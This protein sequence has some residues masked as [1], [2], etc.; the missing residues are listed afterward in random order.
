MP[1]PKAKKPAPKKK[2][3]KKAASSP[4]LVP[5]KKKRVYTPAQRRRK[6]NATRLLQLLKQ[7]KEREEP[8]APAPENPSGSPIKLRN[9]FK[10]SLREGWTQHIFGTGWPDETPFD[11]EYLRKVELRIVFW[12][13]GGIP[14]DARYRPLPGKRDIEEAL[15]RKG[16]R[17]S[18]YEEDTKVTGAVR[19]T[20]HEDWVFQ[21]P[22]WD[23]VLLSGGSLVPKTVTRLLNQELALKAVKVFNRLQL[24]DVP[25]TPTLEDSAGDWFREVVGVIFGSYDPV[26]RQRMIKELFLLV[27]KKNMKTT[28]GALIMLLLLIFN[29]RPNGQAIMT[30]PVHDVAE[31]AFDAISGAIRLDPD[32]A[33]VFEVKEHFKTVIDRRTNAVLRVLTFDPAVLTGQKVFAALIDE[34]HVISKN[35]KA[36][37]A[38]RQIRGGML[39]FPEAIMIFITTQSEEAPAGVFLS[40]LTQA[41]AIRDGVR[42][43]SR[44]LPILYE[45]PEKMQ[46]DVNQPWRKPKTWKLV[47]PNLG[48]SISLDALTASYEDAEAKGESEMR[49]WASQHL[50]IEIG[51]ALRSN[52]WAGAALWST[53]EV[54]LTLTL[55]SLLERCEVVDVGVDGG[56]MDD[57][58]GLAVV[59]REKVTLKWLVWGKAW[60]HPIVFDRNKQIAAQLEDFKKSG[61]LSVV[62]FPGADIEEL[63]DLILMVHKTGLLDKIGLDPYGVGSIVDALLTAGVPEDMIAGVSQGWRMGGAVKTVERAVAEKKLIHANQGILNWCIS[64]AQVEARGN[65]VLITKAA[66]GSA[67]IDVLMAVLDA[68][69]LLSANPA[70]KSR[71]FQMFIMG[72]KG[73]SSMG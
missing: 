46:K 61:D 1:K 5:A 59:G 37:S 16:F 15:G 69:S 43:G 10:G 60:A 8:F 23:K 52:S 73:K 42:L 6:T 36:A 38:I 7:K 34:L 2:A 64:N 22:E 13:T 4:P 39:P 45:F 70:A 14:H 68:V 58:L 18:R 40:E 33:R 65:A 19:S 41:R 47:T 56:G 51:M 54:D 50:N 3:P 44:I 72:G 9:R 71:K 26:T 48:M 28:G 55:K 24:A 63:V 12:D 66:S 29:E 57:L 11:D 35:P 17:G 49:S 62:D 21:L 53:A 30:A 32:L 27:P 25:G 67:K 31:I 20:K